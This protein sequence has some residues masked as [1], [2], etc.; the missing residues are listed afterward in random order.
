MAEL[1]TK[2]SLPKNAQRVLQILQDAGKPL[3]AYEVLDQLRPFGV[4]APPTAYRS[5]DRLLENGLIHRLES[6]SAFVACTRG[7]THGPSAFAVCTKCQAVKET[8][9]ESVPGTLQKWADAEE[10]EISSVTIEALGICAKC[11]TKR[12]PKKA[13]KTKKS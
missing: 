3:T 5:L 7:E 11:R 1:S 4:T 12:P 6:L 13:R 9:G 8:K 10:F 2:T